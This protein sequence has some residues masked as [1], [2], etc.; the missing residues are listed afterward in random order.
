MKRFS[1]IDKDHKI[2]KQVRNICKEYNDLLYVEIFPDNCKEEILNQLL[3]YTPDLV[4]I[5]MDDKLKD[6]KGFFLDVL[7]CFPY[8]P[9][10]VGMSANKEKAFEAFQYE[11]FDFLLKPMTELNIRKSIMKYQKKIGE[12]SGN[13]IC[14]KSHKDYHYIPIDEILYL[15]ADNNTTDFYLSGGTKISAY[16]TLKIFEEQLPRNFLRVHKSYIINSFYVSRIN[17]TKN[18]CSLSDL[19]H[20]IPFTKTFIDNINKINKNLSLRTQQVF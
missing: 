15:A 14:L 12:T 2:I 7:Q 10:F 19:S 6:I 17:Y 11:M 9:M 1:I 8:I 4:F 3:K 16:K 13:I 20:K 18:R 5:D